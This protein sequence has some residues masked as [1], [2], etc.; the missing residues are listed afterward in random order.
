MTI[1]YLEQLGLNCD[2]KHHGNCHFKTY[3]LYCDHMAASY[4]YAVIYMHGHYTHFGLQ[5]FAESL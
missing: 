2:D 5:G 4:C 1:A 3:S